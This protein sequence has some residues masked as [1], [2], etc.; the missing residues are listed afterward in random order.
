MVDKERLVDIVFDTFEYFSQR[1]SHNED[2][3]VYRGE[4]QCKIVSKFVNTLLKKHGQIGS[5]YLFRFFSYQFEMRRQWSKFE[6]GQRKV[7][8]N[9]VVGEKSL[10]YWEKKPDEYWYFVQTGLLKFFSITKEDY[11]KHIGV[12]EEHVYGVLYDSEELDRGRFFNTYKGFRLCI[13]CTTLFHSKS[14]YCVKCLYQEDC[15]KLQIEKYP[16]ILQNCELVLG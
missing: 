2:F 5:D 11:M 8:L 13:D 10:Q 16:H 9:W 12:Q 6:F 14:L 4:K 3:V 7:M 1:F 15:K